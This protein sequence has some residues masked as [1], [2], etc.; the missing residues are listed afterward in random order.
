MKLRVSRF[1]SRAL[2]PHMTLFNMWIA[3]YWP[4][5]DFGLVLKAWL[6]ILAECLGSFYAD[7]MRLDLCHPY[8][9]H[10]LML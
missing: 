3:G 6:G 9:E 4:V 10:L 5:S 7:H 8:I 2:Q 1:S